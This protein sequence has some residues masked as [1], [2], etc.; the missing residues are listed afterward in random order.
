MSPDK[1]APKSFQQRVEGILSKL[2]DSL[3]RPYLPRR[4]FKASALHWPDVVWFD[5]RLPDRLTRSGLPG[6][7]VVAFEVESSS[8]LQSIKAAINNLEALKPALGCIVIPARVAAK[9]RTIETEKYG[10]TVGEAMQYLASRSSLA[11]KVLTDKEL[12]A[13]IPSPKRRNG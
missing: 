6:V 4:E 13:M 9:G 11:I 7:P 3:G 8:S 10:K 12:E 2:H 5:G 1:L